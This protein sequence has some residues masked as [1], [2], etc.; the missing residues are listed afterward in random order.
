MTQVFS[1]KLP[2]STEHSTDDDK[3]DM[4]IKPA[5]LKFVCGYKECKREFR[6]EAGKICLIL[7][8]I[9]LTSNIFQVYY[10]TSRGLMWTILPEWYL[11]KRLRIW[12]RM[13]VDC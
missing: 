2:S 7:I 9:S 3:V 4:L 13:S 6:T 10:N 8:Y 11:S 5:T 1:D 12:K